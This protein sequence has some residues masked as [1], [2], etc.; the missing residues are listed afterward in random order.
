MKRFNETKGCAPPVGAYDPKLLDKKK[1]A[2]FDKCDRFRNQKDDMPAPNAFDISTDIISHTSFRTPTKK[3]SF[4]LT[5]S[6]ASGTK[7]SYDDLK[8]EIVSLK[9][10]L[11]YKDKQIRTLRCELDDT[12]ITLLKDLQIFQAITLSLEE[13]IGD[14]ETSQDGTDKKMSRTSILTG[15]IAKVINNGSRTTTNEKIEL[16]KQNAKKLQE[17]FQQVIAES[18]RKIEQ[19]KE[20]LECKVTVAVSKQE[21]LEKELLHVQENLKSAV[22]CS[23][24]LQ[25]YRNNLERRNEMLRTKIRTLDTEQ[26]DLHDENRFL[27]GEVFAIADDKLQESQSVFEA[28]AEIAELKEKLEQLEQEE[29]ILNTNIKTLTKKYQDLDSTLAAVKEQSN[30]E[31]ENLNAQLQVA[32]NNLRMEKAECDALQSCNKDLLETV[33]QKQKEIEHL[34][35]ELEVAKKDAEDISKRAIA[36]EDNVVDLEIQLEASRVELSNTKEMSAQHLEQLTPLQEKI[37]C[38]ENEKNKL[39]V[40]LDQ[41]KNMNQQTVRE[42]T[43]RIMVLE[44][45]EIA[46]Q[47]QKTDLQQALEKES[48]ATKLAEQKIE[49]TELEIQDIYVRREAEMKTICDDKDK[50]IMQA[51]Q[52]LQNIQMEIENLNQNLLLEKEEH[53]K[54]VVNLE[55]TLKNSDEEMLL[56]KKRIEDKETLYKQ[57][58]VEKD[59]VVSELQKQTEEWQDE[60]R[61]LLCETEDLTIAKLNLESM[62]T[63]FKAEIGELTLK[64]DRLKLE[65]DESSAVLA[66]KL[67]AVTSDKM[68]VLEQM[69]KLESDVAEYR[70]NILALE[71]KL[72]AS[73]MEVE[74]KK[75]D[76]AEIMESSEVRLKSITEKLQFTENSKSEL[77]SEISK[78]EKDL[79]CSKDELKNHMDEFASL[80][81][82]L[83]DLKLKT[84]EEVLDLKK[85]LEK[86]EQEKSDIAKSLAQYQDSETEY[87]ITISTLK[88]KLQLTEMEAEQK[89]FDSS[90]LIEKTKHELVLMTEQF[91]CLQQKHSK[92]EGGYFKLEND[93]AHSET[94]L[95]QC[96]NEFELKLAAKNGVL[97]EYETECCAMKEKNSELSHLLADSKFEISELE[98]NLASVKSKIQV[99]EM[100]NKKQEELQVTIQ[101]TKDKWRQIKAK[102]DEQAITIANLQSNL[103]QKDESLNSMKNHIERLQMESEDVISNMEHLHVA[104]VLHLQS[105][106]PCQEEEDRIKHLNE[107]VDKWQSMYESLQQKVEPFMKQLDAFEIEKQA[108]L[109]RSKDAQS[110]ME[111]LSQRY[112]Q[113][114]GHQNQKQKIHHIVKIKDENNV[115]KRDISALRE[116]ELKQKRVIHRLEQKLAGTEG[117]RKTFDPSKAFQHAKEDKTQTLLSPLKEGNRK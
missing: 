70:N 18:E 45:L 61:K 59:I 77:Q 28:N 90:M 37:T 7:H 85:S 72:Q 41:E 21:E 101:D 91:E 39:L 53:C 89:I 110:E 109:G 67:D 97:S 22:S 115:L 83:D 31:I 68:E 80:K 84:G 93:F 96:R 57:L 4:N 76:V 95:K 36:A 55:D 46:L 42:L 17:N 52:D 49:E 11:E 54:D 107:L 35:I 29:L 33:S 1:S 94:E 13:K 116:T 16:A 58:L 98:H 19:L 82:S 100:E 103:V 24:T 23:E 43:D 117:G 12:V 79:V 51:L 78:L 60:K 32:T 74:Q 102:N 40:D 88:R 6:E 108:L 44:Q 106:I 66:S 92:L 114:L 30:Q 104:E 47:E 15:E 27:K 38:I 34:E 65:T 112:A 26:L 10:H 9:R 50:E 71:G 111:R 73:E 105:R 113:L 2:A 75:I 99:M 8:A 3:G 5:M 86:I 56:F 81:K 20:S 69:K 62:I 63:D 14:I 87:E 25:K 48:V 64:M